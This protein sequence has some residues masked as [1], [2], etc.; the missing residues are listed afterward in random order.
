MTELS[1]GKFWGL[2]RLANESGHFSMLAVDQRPPIKQVVS[3]R[4]GEDTPRYQ[5]IRDVKRTMMEALAPYST[6]VLADP[7]YALTDAMRILSPHHGLVITLEDSLFTETDDGRCSKKIDDWSVAKIKRVGGDAVKVLT[8]YRPD[9]S[10]ET[11]NRQKDFTKKIGEACAKHDIPFLLE[12]LVYPFKGDQNHT[13]DYVEQ[14]GKRAEDVIKTVEE[15]SGPDFGVDIFKLESPI[16]AAD[17]PGPDGDPD[18]VAQCSQYFQELG[19][20][21]NRPW[22][23]LSAGATKPAFKNVMHYAYEAGASGFLAGRAIWWDD[24]QAFPDLDAMKKGMAENAVPYMQSL[25]QM[26]AERALPWQEHAVYAENPGPA[27]ASE[28]NF[29]K[30]YSE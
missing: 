7:T 14:H 17:V 29:A 2:R 4:R 24:F 20:A 10:E 25:S 23:M 11:R 22:V 9:Q 8:W 5:D 1:P 16:P 6:A 18:A 26:T 15:F 13:T 19:K 30:W 12:F 28:T 3:Q 27:G 21:S